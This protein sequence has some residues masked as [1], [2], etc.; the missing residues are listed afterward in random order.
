MLDSEVG[1]QYYEFVF[2][3]CD[4]EIKAGDDALIIFN[5]YSCGALLS[6]VALR[7]KTDVFMFNLVQQVVQADECK[8]NIMTARD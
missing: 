7:R 1:L 2:G 4:T 5:Q 8:A 3:K 6:K